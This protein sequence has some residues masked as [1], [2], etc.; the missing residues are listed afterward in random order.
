MALTQKQ[1][2]LRKYFEADLFEFAKYI[3]PTY[4]YGDIH[5]KVFD[6]LQ[7]DATNQLLLLP[8]GHLKSHC[9]AV[10]V[11][12]MITRFPWTTIVYVSAN[13]DLAKVQVY[14]IQN[15]LESEEYKRLWPE[16]V[17]QEKHDRDKWSQWAINVDH[18]E[19]KKRRVRDFT[20]VV[21]TVKGTATGLH[22]DHL[23][24]DDVVTDANAYTD[25]GRKEVR[26]GVAA[27]TGVKNPGATTK[28]VGTRYHPKDV[29]EDFL[30]AEVQII[31]EDGN[32]TGETKPQ[33]EV[34]SA[35]VEDS[36]DG[37]GNYLWPRTQCP[38]TGQWY[39]FDKGVWAEKRAEYLSL[40]QGAQFWAQY[41]NEPNDPTQDRV[42]KDK[43]RYYERGL[44]SCV[45]GSWFYDGKKLSIY[46]GMDLAFSDDTGKSD[47]S[48]IV[49]IGIDWEGFIYVLDMK[50]Y[51][52]MNAQ[53][54][55]DNLI[56]LHDKWRIKRLKI[57]TNNAGKLIDRQ[58]KTLL[59][60]R[61]RTLNIYSVAKTK[62]D[63]TK[64]ERY[65]LV[66]EP[67]YEQGVILHTKGGLT[68]TLED[69]LAKIRPKN[70]DLKDG[71][72]DA[73]EIAEPPARSSGTNINTGRLE[74]AN[75]RF[76]GKIRR[77]H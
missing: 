31:G 73:I 49:V 48:A 15:M 14:A 67:R 69:Q 40:G 60:Q 47:F 53:T 63:G 12:W 77:R 36:R 54:H 5:E 72:T 59:R 57:E 70:D 28:A 44:L 32:F 39:G 11:V 76:G 52:T 2:E 10:W 21:R 23:V 6:W 19:R 41:Y 74:V 65:A 13:D 25:A 18:P 26:T 61:G 68:P 24:Y 50:M 38:K 17:H 29:Y 3:N 43:F 42:E 45:A 64:L 20:L 71:L 30:G 35:V 1:K 27:F 22:C 4:V 51:K 9:I 46:A 55:Y 62:H 58:I 8:R 37:T 75:S 34:A 56:E 33:W 7:R 66:L 16:M